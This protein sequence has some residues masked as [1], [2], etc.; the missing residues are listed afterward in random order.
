M[1]RCNKAL[2]DDFPQI[3]MFEKPSVTGCPT[4]HISYTKTITAFLLKSNLQP[5]GDFQT[6]WGIT[7]ALT[8]DFGC[9]M[10]E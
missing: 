2:T 1:N 6:L 8:R 9:G 10:M 4:S 7:D 5:L 3:T